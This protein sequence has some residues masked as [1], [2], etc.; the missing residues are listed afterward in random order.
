MFLELPVFDFCQIHKFLMK[1]THG[2]T[3]ICLQ[4]HDTDTC[5]IFTK[6]PFNNSNYQ[7]SLIN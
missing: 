4:Y 7:N 2:R 3:K 5:G 1:N 6:Y